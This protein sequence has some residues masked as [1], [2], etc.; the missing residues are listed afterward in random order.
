MSIPQNE[1]DDS[2]HFKIRRQSP[3]FQMNK[4]SQS[5]ELLGNLKSSEASFKMHKSTE[6]LQI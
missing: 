6:S 4:I 3:Q 5:S 2:S 1:Y